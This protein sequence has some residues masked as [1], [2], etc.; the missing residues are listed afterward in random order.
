MQN[1]PLAAYL[2]ITSLSF[3]QR[4]VYRADSLLGIV[5]EAF[6]YFVMVSVWTALYSGRAELGGVALRGMITYTLLSSVLRGLTG[7]W[8]A[9]R[10]AKMANDGSI[11]QE[12]IRP[13]GLRSKALCEDLGSNLFYSR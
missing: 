11:G 7:S 1:V 5:S 3:R 2:R 12:L 10:I 4:F 6:Y 8:I 13:V 9:H